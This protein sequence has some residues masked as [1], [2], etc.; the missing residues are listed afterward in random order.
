MREFGRLPEH[1]PLPE[2]DMIPPHPKASPKLI[3]PP[4][5]LDKPEE[6]IRSDPRQTV[7]RPPESPAPFAHYRIDHQVPTINITRP[8]LDTVEQRQAQ[9]DEDAGGGCCKCVIM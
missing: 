6:P 8:S 3:L 1:A 7:S 2:E 4:L 9:E 5:N